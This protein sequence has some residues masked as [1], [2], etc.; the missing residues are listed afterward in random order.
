MTEAEKR[1][2]QQAL[3]E[4]RRRRSDISMLRKIYQEKIPDWV[5]KSMEFEQEPV[6]MSRL[7]NLQKK[8]TIHEDPTS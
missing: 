6:S 4:W 8:E 3:Q 1:K 2:A 7:K 5:V